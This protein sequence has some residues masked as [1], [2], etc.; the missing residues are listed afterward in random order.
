MIS[1]K[2]MKCRNNIIWGLTMILTMIILTGS[3]VAASAAERIFSDVP[4]NHWAER[5]IARMSMMGVVE[6]YEDGTYG[7]SR[8]VSR[9]EIIASIIRVMGLEDEAEGKSIPASFRYPASVPTWAQKYVA[10]GVIQGIISGDDLVSFR[11]GEPAKR[12]EVAEFVGKAIELSVA[13]EQKIIDVL[14][15]VDAEDIPARARGYVSLLRDNGIMEGSEDGFRP[16]ANVTRGE[17]AAL[18]ARLDEKINKLP[19]KA[20]RG[21]VNQVTQSTVTVKTPEGYET[22]IVDDDCLIFLKDGKGALSDL[23][24]PSDEVLV[25]KEGFRAK[26][27]DVNSGITTVSPIQKLS[28]KAYGNM[29]SINYYPQLEII[30]STSDGGRQ[31]IPISDDCIIEREKEEVLLKDILPGDKVEIT[32]EDGKGAEILAVLTEGNTEGKIKEIIIRD[33][34]LL[35][36][37]GKN[38][39]EHSFEITSN[40]KIRKDGT[41]VS[42]LDLKAGDYV[43][44]EWESSFATKVYAESRPLRE[45]VTGKVTQVNTDLSMLFISREGAIEDGDHEQ[46]VVFASGGTRI[47]TLDGTVS[48]RLSRVKTGDK[49][50]VVGDWGEGF[51]EAQTIII[52]GA[53]E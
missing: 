40:T 24:P 45:Q 47:V 25:V 26:L 44:V 38:E 50:V 27:I 8:P 4:D 34:A 3:G 7:L 14:P 1:L 43:D 42:L 21:T 17:M 23:T 49:V 52:L 46:T 6:G 31:T 13:T 11:G 15:Y 10:M 20:I 12:F 53:A 2:V 51:I 48:T 37:I 30:I 32:I 36:V 28:G 5:Y 41:T 39:E 33:K 18:M 29:V 22:L 9:F 19:H 16:L 35:T